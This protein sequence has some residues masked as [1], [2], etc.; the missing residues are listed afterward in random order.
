MK[1]IEFI[2]QLKALSI[3]LIVYG[4]NDYTSDFSEYLSSFRLPLFF[5]LSGFV[6]KDKSTLDFGAFIQ[7]LGRRLLLPYFLLSL[8]LYV[9]WLF[10]GRHYGE[11]GTYSPV[12]NFIGIFYSQGG[13]QYMDWGIPMWFLTAL[14]C[15]LLV[16]F[17]VARLQ[18]IWQPFVSLLVGLSGYFYFRMVGIHL[19]W[20]LD[21]AWWFIPFILQ[22]DG[23]R[24]NGLLT[25]YQD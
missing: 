14:F 9:I 10:V 7:K 16:D 21:V 22:E 4:H 25:D 23:L 13:P 2:D 6:R 15:V 12:T 3:F 18:R 19:P 11:G 20:S 1:R 17:F 5:I 8:L 24:K